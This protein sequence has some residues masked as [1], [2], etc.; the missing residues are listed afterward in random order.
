MPQDLDNFIQDNNRLSAYVR[1][2][3]SQDLSLDLLSPDSF[4]QQS[5]INGQYIPDLSDTLDNLN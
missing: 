3:N 5:V 1:F 2:D 4:T